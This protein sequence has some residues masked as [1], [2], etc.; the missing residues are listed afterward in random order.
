MIR[1][2]IIAFLSLFIFSGDVFPQ[3]FVI[4]GTIT[5]QDGAPVPFASVYQQGTTKGTSANSDGQY[6]LKFP[7]G[8]ITLV[9]KSVGYTQET[10]TI[11]LKADQQLNVVLKAQ[12]YQLGDI[13]I[14]AGGPDPAYEIIRN[15]ISKRKSYLHEVESYSCEVYI[16]GLQKMLAAPRRFLGKDIDKLGQQIGLDSNRRGILY[17]SESES[18]YT[19][20]PPNQRH[21]E[22]ISSKVSGSNRSFSFNR[23]SDL[24][25]NFY[26]NLQDWQGLTNR[27]LISPIAD[28]ALSYYN[29]KFLGTTMENGELVNKIQV[30]PR[31]KADPAF[32]GNIY[33]MEDTW[34][35]YSAELYLTKDANINF[36]DTV[37]V[38]QQFFPARGKTWM[39]STVRFDFVGGMFGFRFGGYYTAVFRDYEIEPTLDKNMFREV[40]KVTKDVNKK[41][42]AYWKEA[43]PIPLTAEEIEDYSKKGALA[44]KRASKP[45]LDSL[46]KVNNKFKLV[47]FIFTSGYTHR[48]RAKREYITYSSLLGSAFYNTVEGFGG[49]YTVSYR[50]QIDSATN[51]YVFLNA[52]ARYG[53]ASE[54]FMGSLSGTLPFRKMPVSFAAGSTM[55]D[56][57]PRGTIST[58]GNTVNSLFYERNFLKLY[59][60]DFATVTTSRRVAGGL[61]LSLQAE[62]ANREAQV[63][64]ADYLIRDL[65]NR[66]FTSNNP[67]SPQADVPLFPD[68]QSFTLNM[69]VTYEFSKKYVTYPSG[70]YY[71]PSKYPRLGLSYVKG[72]EGVFG[73]DVD[74]DLLFADITKSD[75]GLGLYGK[76]SFYAGAGKFLN[77][78]KL[79]YTDYR[80]FAGNQA[81][82]YQPAVNRFL[83]LNYYLPSTSKQYLE[84][85]LEHNFGGLFVNKLPLIRKLHL[86]EIVGGNYL[87]TPGYKNYREFY[88][89]LEY[90]GMRVLY[91]GA[92]QGNR[93]TD[94][95]FRIV[96]AF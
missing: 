54:Q 5:D 73:S 89:G 19:V 68:N 6:F 28:N 67:F 50:K 74:Y 9:F 24:D 23:A 76:F 57:N 53:F 36:V 58:L 11:E 7:A 32:A 46:D 21:E 86:Q 65:K 45:Y 94:K 61:L 55:A 20:K 80:H 1:S 48:N 38:N 29:Y 82:R 30:I 27:P 49:N 22:M 71:I 41:D 18:R 25:V 4:K 91:G 84:G 2:F 37:K 51:R 90:L 52:T 31:H 72:I 87:T 17:L 15:A 47:P 26:E 70:R 42:S 35:I 85:H 66:S 81:L 95:G 62:W 34:R 92:W 75:V 40:M 69:R 93:Q 14:K 77:N 64:H 63:N 10:R 83:Y 78:N 8:K 12:V 79:F 39:P 13:A 56:L 44:E 43:R 60:K 3:G 96:Y 16:K 33:I 59:R 88:A